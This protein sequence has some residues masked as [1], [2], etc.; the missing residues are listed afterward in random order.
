MP[1]IYPQA[2]LEFLSEPVL[3]LVQ[4]DIA[5]LFLAETSDVSFNPEPAMA[6]D[7]SPYTVE[8]VPVDGASLYNEDTEAFLFNEDTGQSFFAEEAT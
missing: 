3:G 4:D 8:L 5:L 7:F 2:L 1:V 6:F